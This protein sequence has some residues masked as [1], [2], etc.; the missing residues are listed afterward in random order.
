MVHHQRVQGW[1]NTSKHLTEEEDGD[2]KQR[3]ETGNCAGG[4]GAGRSTASLCPVRM[5]R[6]VHFNTDTSW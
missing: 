1:G 5:R 4:R 6:L 3:G 2:E